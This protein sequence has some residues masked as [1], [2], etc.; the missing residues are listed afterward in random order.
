ML[1]KILNKLN[2]NNIVHIF[3]PALDHKIYKYLYIIIYFSM[4]RIYQLHY[5]IIY[6]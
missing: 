3:Q 1:R 2:S 5:K 6:I 4:Y